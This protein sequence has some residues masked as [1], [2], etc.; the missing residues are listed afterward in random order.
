LPGSEYPHGRPEAQSASINAGASSMT[1]FPNTNADAYDVDI[2]VAQDGSATQ[3]CLPLAGETMAEVY[4]RTNTDRAGLIPDIVFQDIWTDPA[5]RAP[6]ED[7]AHR[8]STIQSVY[9]AGEDLGDTESGVLP[10]NRG[11]CVDDWNAFCRTV[12]NYETHIQPLW[13]VSRNVTVGG[14]LMTY[15]CTD[16]HSNV[17]PDDGS[18]QIPAGQLSLTGE[19]ENNLANSFRDL[20]QNNFAIIDIDGTGVEANNLSAQDADGNVIETLEKQPDGNYCYRWPDGRSI[21][22]SIVIQTETEDILDEEGQVI[23]Q[24]EV[25]VL[26]DDGDPVPLTYSIFESSLGLNAR[27]SRGG[28]RSSDQFRR[29]FQPDF[30]YTYFDCEA[31]QNVVMGASDFDHSASGLFSESELKMLWE[32]LDIGSAYYNNPFDVPD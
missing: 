4:V 13:E 29:L 21:R 8:Y 28:A 12:I 19:I 23:G 15:S 31:G 32:W 6:D 27:L 3:P 18:A 25:P 26:D 10:F 5:Q 24:R 20:I 7:F 30:S 14:Q 22:P 9:D 11:E 16:C 17:N 1:M 2:S